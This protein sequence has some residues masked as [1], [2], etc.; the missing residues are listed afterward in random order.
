[1]TIKLTIC[2]EVNIKFSGLPLDA[3]K[4]LAASFKYE[5]P[6]AKY[7]PAYRLGRW[8]GMVSLF[9]LG[10]NGYLSQ[11]EKILSILSSMN[12]NI[13]E[14]EDN[15]APVTLHFNKVTETYW[16]DQGKCWPAGH[17]YEGDPIML[18]DYQVEA[19][20]RFL[21]NPQSL[22]EIATGAG[23]CQPL[24]CNVLTPDGWRMIKDIESG[25]HVITP[26]GKSVK[27][28]NTYS[29]GNKEVYEIEFSDGR[30]ARCCG[31]HIWRV[32][33]IDWKRSKTG[34]WRNISTK[35]I[36][37]LKSKTSRSIG[38]PLVTM[39]HDDTDIQLPIDPWLIGFLLGDGSFRN[40][41]LGFSTA[42][43]ELVQK[44]KSKLDSDYTVKHISNYDYAIK[45][46]TDEI[47][48]KSHSNNMCN[49]IRNESGHILAGQ[50]TSSNKYIKYLLDIGLM[51]T[52]S[53]T[54]FIPEIYFF[55]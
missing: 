30:T 55:E 38:I 11:L 54:K 27:V 2:D 17:P 26:Q 21:E 18:R 50:T 13:D 36:I 5:I 15:R 28:L 10:G 7:Q 46:A 49:K 44:V 51:E 20:N 12:I 4:K 40:N 32:Y 23:K 35:E 16:A 52:Y 8:D 48:R 29:P 3:R 25:D 9:G 53:H 31:D 22:Q 34:P 37:E 33:N 41:H 47:K 39:D 24:T 1:M 6:Y 45:F 43:D 19:I 14:I 42:D